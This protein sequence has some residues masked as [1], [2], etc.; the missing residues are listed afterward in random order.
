MSE[1]DLFESKTER[2][3]MAAFLR[4]AEKMESNRFAGWVPKSL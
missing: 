1:I 2:R 3:R 4:W